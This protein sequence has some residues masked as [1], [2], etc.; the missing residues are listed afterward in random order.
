M[1]SLQILL[2]TGKVHEV[3]HGD[4]SF[5]RSSAW[6][7]KFMRNAACGVCCGGWRS[8]AGGCQHKMGCLDAR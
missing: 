7:A 5:K 6:G 1:E 8:G 3:V 4:A 2:S